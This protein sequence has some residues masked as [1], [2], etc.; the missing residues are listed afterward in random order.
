MT[1]DEWREALAPKI[2]GSLNLHQCFGNDVDFFI[3][4]S[5]AVALRGN[6]GQ[7]NYAA[8][9]SFQ[10]ALARQR[11]A[12]GMPAYSIN[13]G[14]VLEVGFVS[15]N[16]E[17]AA[18]LRKQGL[19]AISILD[20]LAMLNYAVMHPRS[21]HPA[22]SVC[23][24]G[25]LPNDSDN[26][27]TDRRFAHLIR[28]DAVGHATETQCQSTDIG[29]LLDGAA[30]AKD[31]VKIICQAILQELGKLIASPV[32]SLNAAQSLDSYGIDSLVAVELRNWIGV[33]LQANVPLMILRGASSINEISKIVTKESRL[34]KA[35]FNV[36]E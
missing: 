3:L 17:V 6:V 30:G 2:A 36:S 35:G 7:S 31:T 4:M 15:E 32:E 5:S 19:G 29:R 14:P 10:D 1:A 20:L 18:A 22:E 8:A 11:T 28:H 21:C 26:S 16:P 24:I 12:A 25:M 34:V 9:C 13:I 23:A 33:Y 27:M